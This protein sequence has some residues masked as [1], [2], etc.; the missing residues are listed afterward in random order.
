M[1][2]EHAGARGIRL[3]KDVEAKCRAKALRFTRAVGIPLRHTEGWKLQWD[4]KRIATHGQ[5]ATDILHD[6]AHWCVADPDRR[7][8]PD[9]GL[10]VGP[11]ANFKLLNRDGDEHPP[12]LL[13]P[14]ATDREEE[15]SSLLGILIEMNLGMYPAH[16]MAEHSWAIHGTDKA[17]DRTLSWLADRGFINRQGRLLKI[18]K[19]KAE[20]KT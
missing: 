2:L 20:K 6:V 10:G 12:Q 3:P 15:R 7:A 5:K 13:G 16:T 18:G 11:D 8:V 19:W 17:F 4:G 1:S 9:F 14:S